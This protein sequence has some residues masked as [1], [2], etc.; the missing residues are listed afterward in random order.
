MFRRDQFLDLLAKANSN[1]SIQDA[2]TDLEKFIDE[3]LNSIN[4]AILLINNTK[5]SS[6]PLE[7][8]LEVVDILMTTNIVHRDITV[9]SNNEITAGTNTEAVSYSIWS[10]SL[11]YPNNNSATN[12]PWNDKTIAESLITS[13]LFNG[14]LRIKCP[15]NTNKF[16]ALTLAN[17][18]MSIGNVD[19]NG[20]D[21]SGYWSLNNRPNTKDN[22]SNPSNIITN[23]GVR[24]LY[25]SINDIVYI[26]FKLF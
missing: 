16:V 4:N 8:N 20:N 22:L 17:K 23:D 7:N 26:E 21:I 12:F 11:T 5:A 24:V 2:I 15:Q 18:Y 10:D 3:N 25:D 6:K 9:K 1:E 14:K 13:Y 19:N